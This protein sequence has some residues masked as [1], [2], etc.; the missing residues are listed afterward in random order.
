MRYDGLKIRNAIAKR[1][2][3]IPKFAAEADL[4]AFSVYR[5]IAD[6]QAHSRTLGKIARVLDVDPLDL[7][8]PADRAEATL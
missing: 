5:A 7:L 4:S 2:Q 8:Q 1:E 6:G 3:S